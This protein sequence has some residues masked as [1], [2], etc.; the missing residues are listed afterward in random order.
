[1]EDCDEKHFSGAGDE[2]HYPGA[3][4]H[5]FVAEGEKSRCF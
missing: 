4:R 2:K 3:T 1:M 5:P